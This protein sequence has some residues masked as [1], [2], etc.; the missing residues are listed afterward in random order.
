MRVAVGPVGTAGREPRH[1][2]IGG[3]QFIPHEGGFDVETS[4]STPGALD[5]SP[6]RQLSGLKHARSIAGR[7]STATQEGR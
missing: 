1:K 7:T 6:W 2:A 4:P 5:S 3:A